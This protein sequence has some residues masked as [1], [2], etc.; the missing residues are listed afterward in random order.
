MKKNIMLFIGYLTNGGAERSIINLANELMKYHNVILVCADKVDIDYD[1]N[2]KII[3]VLDLRSKKHRRRGLKKVKEIKKKYNIDISISY[4]TLFNYF[5]VKTRYKEKVY[6]SI[7]NHLSAKKEDFRFRLY[8][9]ISTLLCDKVICCSKSVYYDQLK[10]NP[11]QKNKFIV[12]ENF[13]DEEL[14]KKNMKEKIDSEDKEYLS[15]NLI[16]DMA[17]LVEH[18]GHRNIIKAMSIVVKE[19]KDAKLLIFGRGPLYTKLKDLIKDYKL[20]KNVYLM[21]F[22]KNPF[23]FLKQAKMFILASDYEGFPNVLIEAM[24]C[25]LPIISTNS[26]GGSVEIIE[27]DYKEEIIN[28]K[29]ECK[30]GILIPSFK[31]EHN[32]KEI[33][34]NEK[35]LASTI[36]D[37]LNNKDKQKLYSKKSI[38]RVKDFNKKIIIKKWL[39]IIKNVD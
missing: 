15:D 38:E 12:I 23:K 31:E 27:G 10:H 8:H 2:V 35:I 9:K 3:E 34:N 36:L 26:K 30:Y 13:C 4:T 32:N 20:E 39:E 33:T 7:R 37:L 21:S 16:I 25:K 5:N 11:Y 14:I 1:C 19:K 6:I 29:K 17:R 28:N 24:T 18:K 22:Y